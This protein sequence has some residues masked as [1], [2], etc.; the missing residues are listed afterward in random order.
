[1]TNNDYKYGALPI[2]ARILRQEHKLTTSEK[3]S[4][5]SFYCSAL[6]RGGLAVSTSYGGSNNLNVVLAAGLTQ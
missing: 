5:T 1:M 3:E 4:S 6:G 2:L